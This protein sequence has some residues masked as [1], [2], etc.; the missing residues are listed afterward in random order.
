WWKR[1]LTRRRPTKRAEAEE[2]ALERQLSL[3]E[4]RL[5]A[6]LS[7]IKGSGAKRVLDLGCGQ[8]KLVRLLLADRQFEEIVGMD[9]SWR[10]LEIGGPG[11]LAVKRWSIIEG[12]EHGSVSR[13]ELHEAAG[14]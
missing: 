2:A 9:V 10:A 5:G 6:V 12:D 4:Q 11:Y 13:D 1:S 7:V 3:N 14:F 8:G